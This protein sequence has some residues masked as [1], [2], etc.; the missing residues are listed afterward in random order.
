MVRDLAVAYRELEWSL[1]IFPFYFPNFSG[2]GI[3]DIEPDILLVVTPQM[4]FWYNQRAC[5][6]LTTFFCC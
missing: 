6:P 4:N 3:P 5:H 2:E 1:C